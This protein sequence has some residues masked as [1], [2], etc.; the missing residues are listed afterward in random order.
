MEGGS[1]NNNNKLKN[2]PMEG[3]L[4]YPPFPLEIAI[5]TFFGVNMDIFW[6]CTI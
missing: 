1:C 2:S 6:N 3:F 4:V 5:I